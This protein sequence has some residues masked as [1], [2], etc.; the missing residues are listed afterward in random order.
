[1]THAIYLEKI[2]HDNELVAIGNISGSKSGIIDFLQKVL[3]EQRAAGSII[4]EDSPLRVSY[5]Y[6][7]TTTK[8]T[9]EIETRLV[10][11]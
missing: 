1:M 3:A 10:N 11:L 6:S 2:Y 4:H 7:P 5:Q 9:L 8:V